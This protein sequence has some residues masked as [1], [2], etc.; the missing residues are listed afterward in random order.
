MTEIEISRTV[1]HNVARFRKERG[2][3]LAELAERSGLGKST[4]S[5]LES[6]DA[7]PSIETLWSVATA[8]GVPFGSLLEP[9]PGCLTVVR[10]GH[11]QQVEAAGS[12]LSVW[13]LQRSA[14]IG[15][16]EV[17]RM[18]L[19]AGVSRSARAHLPGTNETVIAVDG[20]IEV[21]PAESLT[22][23]EPGDLATFAADVDHEYRAPEDDA[24]ALVVL[25]YS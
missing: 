4:L 12:G 23:L 21:G 7:N 14:R 15:V 13:L 17:Y 25:H 2:L 3:S 10:A 1:A 5:V 11:G 24:T 22:R 6:G 18:E 8:L 19:A 9:A 20:T 16:S